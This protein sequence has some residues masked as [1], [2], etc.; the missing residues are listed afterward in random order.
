[1]NSPETIA[2]VEEYLRLDELTKI[3]ME[4]PINFEPGDDLVYFVA[5]GRAAVGRNYGRRMFDVMPARMIPVGDR[6]I[7]CQRCGDMARAW[8]CPE[9]QER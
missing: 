1:M 7:P 9:H 8:T 4:S 5:R 3:V 6:Q 2:A